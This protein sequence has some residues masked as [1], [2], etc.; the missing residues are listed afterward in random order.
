LTTTVNGELILEKLGFVASPRITFARLNGFW[1][2]Q[3]NTLQNGKVTVKTLK[4]T[5]MGS[6]RG[7][8]QTLSVCLDMILKPHH[9]KIPLPNAL[10]TSKL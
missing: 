6:Q 7:T 5:F 1:K 2:R 9:V 10:Q 3:P 4:P 8:K